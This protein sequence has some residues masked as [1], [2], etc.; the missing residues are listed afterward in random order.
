[1]SSA[2]L[3]FQQITKPLVTEG[4]VPVSRAVITFTFHC[5]L[6]NIPTGKKQIKN[7]WKNAEAGTKTDMDIKR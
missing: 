7:L 6:F 3:V 2:D 1:M 5:D 4:I